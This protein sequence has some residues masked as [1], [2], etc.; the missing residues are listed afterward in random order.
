M[1]LFDPIRI[2]ASGAAEDFEI[3]RSLRFNDNDSPV[4]SRTF[5][6]AGNRRTF[7]FSVWCKI[8]NSG[9]FSPFFSGNGTGGFFKFQF[10]DDTRIE[11]NTAEGGSDSIQLITTR[12]FRDPTAWYH[13]V[14]ACDTTQGSSS[15]RVKLYI[16][17]TQET[18]FDTNTL[19]SQ[20]HQTAVNLA[21]AHQVGSRS[22]ASAYFDGYITE[23]NFIDGLQLTPASFGETN[24]TTGQ[25]VPKN[26]G[27]LTYGTNGFRLQFS[28]NS[29][30]SATTLGK[31][32]S[33]NGNNWTPNNF[34][35]TANSVENDSV[36]DTPTNNWCTLNPLTGGWTEGGTIPLA[37]GNLFADNPNSGDKSVHAT[38]T[39]K[40]GKKYYIEGV[41]LEPSGGGS[42]CKW[43]LSSLDRNNGMPKKPNSTG[44]FG[45]DWRGGAGTTQSIAP[46]GNSNIGSRPA[47]GTVIGVAID[48]VNGKFY[49]HQGNTY[50][51]SGNPDN[52][53]GAIV[54]S[55]P[56]GVDYF[57]TTS[58]DSGGPNFSEF[59]INFGQQ[60]FQHQPSTFTDLANSQS[61]DE[62]T[63]LLPNKHFG[64]L[65]YSAG[66]SNGT[67]TFT[68]SDAVDFF[69]DWTWLKCRSSAENHYLFDA[70]R[71]NVDITDKFLQANNT[72][73]E[74]GSGV[75]GTTVSSIQNGI[76]IVE[77]SIGSG[78]IYFTNRNYVTW[79]W[80]AGGSTVTNNDGAIS[81]QVR[82]NSTAGFSIITYTGDGGNPSTVGHGLGVA[83]D[84]V[85]VKNRSYAANWGI[86]HHKNTSEPATEIIYLNSDS[87]T[88]DR[89]V[90]NDTLPTSTV[91]S[92]KAF[93]EVNNINQNYV[94]YCFSEVAGYSKFG[95][96]TGNGSTDGSFVFTG[97]R[98]AFILLKR[99]NTAAS[100][101]IHDDKRAGYNGD[102]DYLHPDNSQA[103]SDG[104]SGTLDIVANG[105]KLRMTAGT[106]NG[107]GDTFIYLAFAEA[108]FKYARAR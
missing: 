48:L 102:N 107:S 70:L 63:I 59:K 71:G 94:A 4:L 77:T 45:I 38:F 78:E 103:E 20:N 56:T 104:S 34:N 49:A 23:A 6:S 91:F 101:V 60:G 96:Y 44:S 31:D 58:V 36:L 80:N 81:S 68:D 35:V 53:T 106:H 9:T 79:N 28:D 86:F 17:G 95:S 41:Y 90:F 3:D 87:A 10:R 22:D 61:L 99:T 55:I 14:V 40:A 54:T 57:F 76:K 51:N 1:A 43:A 29:G 11:I 7:T 105:F 2:G 12:R 74:T 15:D 97:F 27:G 30:T 46:S 26:T 93:D 52:G 72:G 5:S 13:I 21:I 33:G 69:P 64:T 100:W 18:A 98:P 8:T 39:L 32:T 37:D 75:D 83:A 88:Q 16:N 89:A 42:Q 24:A 73:T 92:V 50:Y 85:I 108:P 65:L 66:S 67:F 62:P 82:T 47:S 84:V 25:W 19:P